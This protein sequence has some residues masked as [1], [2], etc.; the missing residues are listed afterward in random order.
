MLIFV[1]TTTLHE[2]NLRADRFRNSGE[3][4]FCVPC[5]S[6][7]YVPHDMCTKK[8]HAPCNTFFSKIT[9]DEP[10]NLCTWYE[11]W[12]ICKTCQFIILQRNINLQFVPFQSIFPTKLSS[13]TLI[14]LQ[15]T[16]RYLVHDTIV[17]KKKSV[18]NLTMILIKSFTSIITQLLSFSNSKELLFIH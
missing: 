11:S 17:Q 18:L 16:K 15:H 13:C 3:P 14:I 6:F 8:K 10:T 1:K 2:G 12:L 9:N 4:L 7:V 5:W